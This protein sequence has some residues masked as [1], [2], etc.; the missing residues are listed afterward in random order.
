MVQKEFKISWIWFLT[1]TGKIF[2]YNLCG[3]LLS[4]T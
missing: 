2:V 4:V 3:I 1:Y